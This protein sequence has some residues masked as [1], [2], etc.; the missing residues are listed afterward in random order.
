MAML[1]LPGCC[2]SSDSVNPKEAA[3]LQREEELRRA[4]LL[5]DLVGNPFRRILLD[6]S[7]IT[8]TVKA[9]ARSIYDDYHFSE[10]P[11][12][13]DALED[14]GF[15]DADILNHCREPALHAKGCW[16]VDLVLE[17]E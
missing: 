2:L 15:Q 5:R 12:L 6:S 10:M 9:L 4:H 14:A 7:W 16:V 8:P 17:R 1:S 11:I 13:G 3:R